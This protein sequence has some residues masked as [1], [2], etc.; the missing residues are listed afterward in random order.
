MSAAPGA[1]YCY[2]VFAFDA[3]GNYA[4]AAYKGA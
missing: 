4:R 1:T 3:N 2:G